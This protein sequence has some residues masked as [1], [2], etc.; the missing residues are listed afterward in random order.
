MGLQAKAG[1]PSA[2]IIDALS[3]VGKGILKVFQ[4]SDG[5]GDDI[6]MRSGSVQ[7]SLQVL[8]GKDSLLP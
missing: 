5:V 2:R 1:T 4:L 7:S 3:S 8:C 6:P